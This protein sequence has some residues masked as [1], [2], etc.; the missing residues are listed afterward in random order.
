MLPTVQ[1]FP[2]QS[3]VLGDESGIVELQWLWKQAQNL[4]SN[5]I[6]SIAPDPGHS[7]RDPRARLRASRGNPPDF[8]H[9]G[10]G[11]RR[12]KPV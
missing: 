10:A 1:A 7:K 2:G 3:P 11:R 12:R 5:H 9:V 4:W 8:S 6:Q